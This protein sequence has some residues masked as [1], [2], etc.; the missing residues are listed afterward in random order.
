MQHDYRT[1]A[2][3]SPEN[4]KDPNSV[5]FRSDIWSVGVTLFQ[6]ISQDLPFRC[7][8][9][10]TVSIDIAG[11]MDSK[12]PDVR[13]IV[14][15]DLSSEI[16]SSFACVV[17]RCLE[18]RMENRFSTVDEM[19]TALFGC[20]VQKGEAVYSAFISYRVFSEKY[21]AK[22]LYELLNNTVTKAGH[23]VIVYLDTKRLIKGE[24]WEVGF[25]LGLLNSLMVLPIISR[26]VLL[27]MT[28]LMGIEG[29]KQDNVLKELMMTKVLMESK[30]GKLIKIYPILCGQE[31]D[32]G[33]PEYPKSSCFF[34]E[35]SELLDKLSKKNSPTTTTSVQ[36]FFER[37]NIQFESLENMSVQS[38][39]KYI[40]DIE[41]YDLSYKVGL[42]EEIIN[43][44]CELVKELYSKPPVPPFDI[45][46]L[47]RLKAEL[48][49][50][51][52][53]VHEVLDRAL[54]EKQKILHFDNEVNDEKHRKNEDEE[55][56]QLCASDENMCF[57]QNH[58][59]HIG[60]L[61]QDGF[62][63][64]NLEPDSLESASLEFEQLEEQNFNFPFSC[65]SL[66]SWLQ[67]HWN[68]NSQAKA[69][70]DYYPFQDM[71]FCSDFP[72]KNTVDMIPI[73]H[74]T[75]E[76]DSLGLEQLEAK[77]NCNYPDPSISFDI[78]K[79][80]RSDAIN[81]YADFPYFSLDSGS[82]IHVPMSIIVDS[83]AHAPDAV[84]SDLIFLQPAAM[85][86]L[87]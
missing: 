76:Y 69:Y 10:I 58:H 67:P 53:S 37:E 20:L 43:E 72:D 75:V 19:A 49:S 68:L 31:R 50:M 14:S 80:P 8:S 87:E 2:Y 48:K 15:A 6:L 84:S 51:I 62:E 65:D 82:N 4:F 12:A 81:Q 74:K 77:A 25:S 66:S 17:G 70:M 18:K 21:H 44:D 83:I 63:L 56:L 60:Q 57:E 39:M 9:P 42:E 3:T 24:D 33:D 85:L 22:L 54:A 71:R 79:L 46:Q 30:R 41:G 34:S 23:R 47:Q 28:N 29:D 7:Y 78:S 38:I 35:C 86:P 16:S 73:N 13:D 1:P 59:Q 27:P 45:V 52:P 55:T 61:E 64:E 40:L 26:G 5:S 11:D 32:Q 36:N